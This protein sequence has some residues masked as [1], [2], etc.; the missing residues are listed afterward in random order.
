MNNQISERITIAK[1]FK[2]IHGWKGKS[3]EQKEKILKNAASLDYGIVMFLLLALIIVSTM[4]IFQ[5]ETSS[6][7][8]A[9]AGL[10][11]VMAMSLSLRSPFSFI[12]L[13]LQKHIKKIDSV[14]SPFNNELNIEFENIIAR[15][16]RR[17]KHIY[18]T[19]IPVI[20]I[21]IS[22]LLQ[23]LNVNPYWDKF[24]IIVLAVCLYLVVRINFDIMNLRRNL[25]RVERSM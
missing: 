18:L 23:F 4:S 15:L 9:N 10:L 12:E 7:N 3:P 22:A 19:G 13:M 2:S 1:K 24:P 21:F 8:W 25:K 14:K 16:N 5:I 17:K 6:D 11:V 20:L